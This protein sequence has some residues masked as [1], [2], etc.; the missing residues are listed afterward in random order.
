M[1]KR[2]L[3][4]LGAIAALALALPGTPQEEKP[5]KDEK[6]ELRERTARHKKDVTALRGLDFKREVTVG[7]YSKKELLDFLKA[8]FEKELPR[9][10]AARYQRGYAKFGL[11]PEDLD[12]YQAY[13]DLFGSSIA[14]FYH[15]KTKELRLI[16]SGED[17]GGEAEQLKALGIDMEA[18]TLVHELTH[19]AQDQ[20]YEL[21]TLPLEDETND[22]LIMA[23]KAVIEG[24]ASAVGWKYQFEDKFDLIIRGI[25]Q[26]YKSGMLPGPAGRLPAYLRLSLTFPYGYGTDFVVSY[27]KSTKGTLKDASRLFEDFPL[28]SEQILHPEKYYGERD[29]PTLVTLPDL[30]RLFGTPWKESFNNVHG[31]FS[32]DILLKEYLRDHLR[33]MPLRRAREGWDGDR[34]VVLEREGTLPGKFACPKCEARRTAAGPCP[35]CGI[36]V[37]PVKGIVTMYVWYSTWDSEDDAREF[38][39]AYALLLEKKYDQPSPEGERGAKTSFETPGGHVLV[40]RRGTDVLVLDGAEPGMLAKVDDLWKGVRKAEMTGFERVKSFV[41]AKCAVKEAFSG[42]CPKCGDLLKYQD[43]K[44]KGEKPARPRREY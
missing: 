37:R 41:C 18:I 13:M 34:Y 9:D 29:N 6:A 40:E 21:S 26:T 15:P 24:D 25:N 42:P 33:P 27:L 44:E 35:D 2:F 23:L 1:K 14:G 8:E 4:A 28:S 38:A 20:H 16:R 31:E 43:P 12:I 30:E 10:K 11:I 32:I 5:G 36:P 22:D 19:A 17:G 39:D 7:V 3:A